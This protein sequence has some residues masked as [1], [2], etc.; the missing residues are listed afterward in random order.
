MRVV[1]GGK[2]VGPVLLKALL[3]VSLLVA[4]DVDAVLWLCEAL[5]LM[6]LHTSCA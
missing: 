5:L 6:A 1:P 2:A 4:V 3:M